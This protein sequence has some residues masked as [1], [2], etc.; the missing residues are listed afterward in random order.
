VDVGRTEPARG[1]VP[2]ESG[3]WA[4]VL[5]DMVAF[6]ALFGVFLLA[7]QDDPAAFAIS[8]D[9]LNQTIGAVNL[10][11]LLVSSLLV[12]F[13]VRC[14]RADARQAAARYFGGAVAA[15]V[16]FLVIKSLEYAQKI[17]AGLDPGTNDF[18][19]YYYATTGLHAAHVALGIAGLLIVR[20]VAKRPEPKPG[21]QRLV[22][23]GATFW[24]MV[25]FLWV[26]IFPLVYL[27]S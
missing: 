7:R 24:H 19:M 16:L 4:L 11:V 21:D 22:E 6:G 9:E 26:L 14:M 3:L 27:A 20:A 5:G 12:V 13:G 17:D 2:G 8:R 1:H 18:F 10:L 15:G 23:I 25:D